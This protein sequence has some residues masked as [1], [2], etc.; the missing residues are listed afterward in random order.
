MIQKLF[1]NILELSIIMSVV[2]LFVYAIS[3]I[4]EKKYS[5]RWKYYIWI[6]I[7]IRLMIPITYT[8]PDAPIH[9]NTEQMVQ[10]SSTLQKL[11]LSN[12]TLTDD[13]QNPKAMD[14]SEE[15]KDLPTNTLS[16][17]QIGTALWVIGIVVFSFY[18]VISYFFFVKT[19]KRWSITR[20]LM[21]IKCSQT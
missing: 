4:F 11:L 14:S 5:A 9:I 6:L 1:L 17:L 13:I 18:H 8:I 20:I 21:K 3:P 19:I 16:L 12:N 15:K 10:E 7:T 2:I